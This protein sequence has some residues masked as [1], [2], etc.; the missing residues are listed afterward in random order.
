M[1]EKNSCEEKRCPFNFK[2][3]NF[4]TIMLIVLTLKTIW[5]SLNQQTPEINLEDLILN[6]FQQPGMPLFNDNF[7]H[8]PAP[9]PVCNSNFSIYKLIFLGFFV[10]LIFMIR[11]LFSISEDNDDK[12]PRCPFRFC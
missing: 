3:F 9:P 2:N 11:D 4:Q 6:K 10:Y 7:I 12:E 1:T 8:M 5:S